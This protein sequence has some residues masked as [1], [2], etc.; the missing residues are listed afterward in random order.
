MI[1]P[2]SVETKIIRKT[3]KDWYMDNRVKLVTIFP[4]EF[5]VN[6]LINQQRANFEKH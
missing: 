6:R 3:G 1:R 5:R 4:K 2:I